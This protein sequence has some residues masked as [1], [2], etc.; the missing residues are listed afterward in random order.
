VLHATAA[1]LSDENPKLNLPAAPVPTEE[2]IPITGLRAAAFSNLVDQTFEM[3]IEVPPRLK[4]HHAMVGSA[5]YHFHKVIVDGGLTAPFTFESQRH[6]VILQPSVIVD[7]SALIACLAAAHIGPAPLAD[8]AD[9]A[10]D[11]HCPRRFAL[12]MLAFRLL[13]DCGDGANNFRFDLIGRA[14]PS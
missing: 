6:P 11:M 2:K 7:I 3:L 14:R 4:D 5:E 8:L 9:G 10:K 1:L 13:G 12:P